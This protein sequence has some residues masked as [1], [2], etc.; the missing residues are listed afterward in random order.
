MIHALHQPGN[1]QHQAKPVDQTGHPGMGL[2]QQQDVAH[3]KQ[4][5][6]TIKTK[7]LFAGEMKGV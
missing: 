5:Q 7:E 4:Y 3:C 2:P 6:Q 1:A